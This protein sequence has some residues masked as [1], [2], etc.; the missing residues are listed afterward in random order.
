[1]YFFFEKDMR[2]EVSYISKRCDQSNNKNLKSFD[3][4]QD[5]KH[6]CLD[7]NNLYGYS[8]FKFLPTGEFKWIDPKDYDLN[9]YNK[10]V[11]KVTFSKL[12]WNIQNNYV[13]YT[14][15]IL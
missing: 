6:S 1:M 4:K 13:S 2:G 9:E 8:M 7:A 15:I 12:I 14:M 10:I 3:P 11:E 5:L